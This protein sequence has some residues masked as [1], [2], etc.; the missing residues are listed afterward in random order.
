MSSQTRRR[1]L[2]S[3]LPFACEECNAEQHNICSLKSF[4][5]KCPAL[6][7]PAARLRLIRVSSPA[8]KKG[9]CPLAIDSTL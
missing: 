6:S 2:R 3:M 9:D 4:F 7:R 1:W 5:C 8:S